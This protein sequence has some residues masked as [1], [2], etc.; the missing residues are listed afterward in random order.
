MRV[1]KLGRIYVLCAIVLAGCAGAAVTR[2]TQ[3][4]PAQSTRPSQILVYP[5]A[6]DTSDVTLNQSIIQRAYRSASGNNENAAQ[7]QLARQTAELV[8]STVVSNLNANGYSAV[9]GK[10]GVPV[11]GDN[12][13]IVDGEF[14]DINEGN[15]LRR[16][17][18]GLGAGA[19]TLDTDVRVY[20]RVNGNPQQ[21]LA[22]NTH[23]DSGKMPGAGIMAPVGAAAG[24]GAAATVGVN[25]A[26][27][28]VKTY[29]SSTSTLAK[30]TS[31]QIVK[32]IADYFV[33][34][35]W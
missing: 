24:A 28:G 20:Q 6:V 3:S 34:H 15:R 27:G 8:C 4:E 2:Q 7:L 10:R 18:I 32:T 31:D 13:L 5:F 11:S 26:A 30:K 25:A 17:V 21:V 12:V 33:Q 14:T 16:M 9:C 19:S 35:G 1:G 23:A 22:F 29:T